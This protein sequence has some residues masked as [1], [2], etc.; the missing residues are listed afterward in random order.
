MDVLIPDIGDFEE[1]DVIEI[2]VSTGDQISIE[3][4]LMTLES[5]KATMDIPSPVS[6]TVK[7]IL[8]SVGN[9]VSK[10]D[11]VF[12]IEE[13]TTTEKNEIERKETAVVHGEATDS[14]TPT[15]VETTEIRVPD[16]GDFDEVDIIE[17]LVKDGD[18]IKK[19]QT[20]VVLESDKATMDLP[21]PENGLIQKVCVGL[22][23]KVG[24]GDLIVLISPSSPIEMTNQPQAHPKKTI[25][26]TSRMTGFEKK[27]ISSIKEETS[28]APKTPYLLPHASPSVRKFARELGV[29]IKIVQG[30]G[31][32]SRILHSDIREYV[33]ENLTINNEER[34]TFGNLPSLPEI[35]Y[36]RFGDVDR[37]E[38]TKIQKLTGENL[39]R[40][41][42]TAPHV[43]QMDE[44][45]ITELERF[46]RSKLEE[47]SKKR[48]KL[49]LL[50]F[51]VNAAANSLQKF[52][53]FNSSLNN[54]LKS[55]TQ[56][57]YVNIGIAVNTERGLIVPVIK[58]A[59][60]KG[61]LEIAEN[62]QELAEKA[63]T[64]KITPPDLEGGNFTISNLGG[65]SGTN[66]TPVINVPEVAILG[67][68]PSKMSPVWL[69]GSF[70]PRLILPI[71]LSY[72]HRVIDGVAGAQFTAYFTKILGDIRQ[73]LL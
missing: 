50:A 5:D 8:V 54:D 71:T 26:E 29:D 3:A 53:R 69:D 41:W 66:F 20:L 64:N 35:D 40:S 25:P 51:I 39:H 19:E 17:I 56:K 14:N 10:G 60:K 46:R 36:S 16:I 37:I 44:A 30:S 68:S 7:Q 13:L 47:T 21:S 27:N 22:G 15:S 55:V 12:E 18:K 65:I 31:K 33:K 43:F 4:P 24:E 45:D 32:K 57:K 6:G 72:D 61:V 59:D 58:E 23:D 11:K 70:V 42:I 67:I 49:T 63:R 48:T 9:K 1:V 38:L 62:I 73:A 52:P 28:D 2:L 34:K